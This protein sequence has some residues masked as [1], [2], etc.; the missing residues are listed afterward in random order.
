M[1]RPVVDA[2]ADIF[3]KSIEDG[4]DWAD[5]SSFFDASP[6][7]LRLGGVRL[8]VASIY[9]PSRVDGELATKMALRIVGAAHDAARRVGGFSIVNTLSDLDHCQREGVIAFAFGM[10]GATPLLGSV[11]RLR[12]FAALGVRF[13]GLTH[14]HDN[15]CGDGC[16]AK[17]PTG[18]TAK[19]RSMIAVAEGAGVTLDVAH[20]N[21][22][23]FGQLVDSASYPFVC[24]HAGCRSLLDVPRNLTDHQIR[25]LAD[26][27]GVFGVDA[28]PGHVGRSR[29]AGTIEDMAR[30]IQHAL[31][32][33]GEDHVALGADFDG[34]PTK[35]QGF[36]DAARYPALFE[37]L[38]FKGV[39]D[40]ALEKLASGNWLRVIRDALGRRP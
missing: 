32:L 38:G 27:G 3:S 23:S 19:G 31:D 8:Q 2:H 22:V 13:L 10:E 33:V 29:A 26:S 18:L 40:V 37:Y 25:L 24:T 4:L 35:L 39:S 28:F 16:F 6:E 30:H 12:L 21:P 7:K 14:N 36:E 1:L 15:E 20:L 11:D 9:V 17:A 34:I 5:D